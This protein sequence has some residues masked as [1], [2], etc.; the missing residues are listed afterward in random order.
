MKKKLQKE[1]SEIA[2]ELV[3]TGTN[4]DVSKVKQTVRL[5]YEK[6][7]VLEYLE[8][9][10]EGGAQ[11][12][13]SKSFREQNWFTEPEPVPQPEHEEALVEPVMEKIKDLVA[14]MPHEGGKVDELL[15]QVLPQRNYMKNDIEEFASNYREMPVFERKEHQIPPKIIYPLEHK[16]APDN[17]IKEV[18]DPDKPKSINEA[19]NTGLN[20]GL[21]DRLAFIKH[22]FNGSADDYARVLSQINTMQ[23]FEQA[24]TFIKGKIKPDYGYWLHKDEYAERFMAIVEK[25]FN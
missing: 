23:S 16:A 8:G 25:R 11:S 3:K 18:A 10:L 9:Q 13:D 2:L 19:V 22:L 15:E 6:L 17:G 24:D 12:F 14:Q 1:I 20:I 21:N 4:Y 5:L 7:I